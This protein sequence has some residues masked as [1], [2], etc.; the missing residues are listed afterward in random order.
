MRLLTSESTGPAHEAEQQTFDTFATKSTALPFGQDIALSELSGP[1]YLTAQTLVQQVAYALSETIFAYSPESFDLD[2]A[3]KAWRQTK[4]KNAYGDVTTVK[5]LETRNGAGTIALGYMFYPDFDMA[6]RHRPQSIVASAASLTHLRP[7]LDELSLLY[8]VASP[9]VLQIA[10]VDYAPETKTGLVTDYT[11][12]LSAA[13]ELGL[14]LVSSK[15]AYEVQHMGLLATLMATVQPTIHI[16]DGIT[17]G[18]E[19]TRVIDVLSTAGLK[20]TYDTVLES[21]KGSLSP[22][23][24]KLSNEARLAK[25][26]ASFNEELGTEYKCFEYHGHAEPTSVLVVFGT[27]EASLGAQVAEALA[28]QGTRVGVI[29]V[30]VYRPFAEEEFLETLATTV[31]Q[32]AVLGQ[33]FDQ[34]SV[35]DECVTSALY[36][37]VLAAVSLATISSGKQPSV[38]DSKYSRQTVWTAKKMEAVFRQFEQKAGEESEEITASLGLA[39]EETKQYAFWDIAS[40]ASA[41]APLMIGQLLSGDSALNVSVRSSHDNSVQS[42]VVR[43]DLRCSSKS[44]EAAYSVDTA[45]VVVIGDFKLL[46]EFNVIDSVKDNGTMVIKSA[47]WKDE[48]IEKKLS[49]PT[50][51]AIAAKSVTLFILDPV[52]SNTVSEEPELESYL[53]QLAFLKIANPTLYETGLRKL[54][55]GGN[56]LD[57]LAKDLETA[58]KVIEVPSEWLTIELEENVSLPPAEDLNANSF[59]AVKQEETDAPSR[60]KSWTVAAK[61]LLFKEVY[62]TATT[63]R[64]DLPQKTAVVHVKEHRRLTP[65]TYDRNIFH[66]EFDLGTSGLKYEI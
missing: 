42:G 21:V 47:G 13:E 28:K 17:V 62:G 23:K 52:A 54:Q 3:A 14:G 40:I 51:K 6:K 57:A 58:L 66:I 5:S 1:T 63:L 26:L 10:A 36:G 39:S 41:S 48:D 9:T 55:A 2:I 35:V 34:A 19:T 64:P 31:Q 20:K 25:V 4:E 8:D 44:I 37:D 56:V 61:G 24:R 65:L 33:V 32:I 30:R 38:Y 60:T 29:S 22:K 59:A 7:A 53:F 15:S 16:Y 45:D 46:S 27:V 11:A 12:A 50:R 43:T 18:R 49:T